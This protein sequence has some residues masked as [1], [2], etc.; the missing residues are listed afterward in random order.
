VSNLNPVTHDLSVRT[1]SIPPRPI[2]TPTQPHESNSLLA[3]LVNALSAA[4]VA[5]ATAAA[6]TGKFEVTNAAAVVAAIAGALSDYQATRLPQEIRRRGGRPPRKAPSRPRAHRQP[7]L[8]DAEAAPVPLSES[9]G[10]T[11]EVCRE[12]DGGR[13]VAHVGGL[14]CSLRMDNDPPLARGLNLD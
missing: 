7:R 8:S 14:P 13:P 1:G 10:R 6:D 4:T 12:V 3:S 11:G 5:A 9:P 2:E